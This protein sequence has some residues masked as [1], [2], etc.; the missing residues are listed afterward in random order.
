MNKW[1]LIKTKSRQEKIAKA[2]LENQNYDVYCPFA[3]ID[4]KTV[5]LFPGYLF[6][7]LDEKAQNW[8]PIRSTKGVLNF[9]RFGLSYANI[10]D[11]IIEVIQANELTTSEKIKTLNNFDKG[12]SVQITEGVLKN[13]IAIFESFKSNDRVILLM[14]LMGQQQTINLKRK[15]LIR[16]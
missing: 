5:A 6:I 14:N 15:S 11:N 9:V 10:A 4:N 12:D 1:Y 13:C 3:K 8:S 16:L 7:N 2:N